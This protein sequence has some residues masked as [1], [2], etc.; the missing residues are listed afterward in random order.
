MKKILVAATLLLSLSGVANAFYI[1]A[2]CQFTGAVGTC[3]VFNQWATPI[4]CSL[5]AEGQVSSGVW[6]SAWENAYIYP[7][8][9][10]YVYVNANNPWIDPLVFVR[11]FANCQF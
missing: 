11:G 2:Q 6:G 9:Y 10:G 1:Q 5:Q 7:G 4:A 3:A 8:Q